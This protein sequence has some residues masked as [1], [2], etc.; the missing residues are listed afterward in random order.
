VN[1]EIAIARMNQAIKL[2]DK[3][4]AKIIAAAKKRLEKP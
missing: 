3:Q 4:A 2:A 1:A